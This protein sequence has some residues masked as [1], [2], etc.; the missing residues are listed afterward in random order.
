MTN[1]TIKVRIKNVYGNEL[2]YPVCADAALLCSLTGQKTLSP[3][4]LRQI[5]ALGYEIAV[6]TPA[7]AGAQ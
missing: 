3:M 6:E 4:H 7:L 5:K 1:R 2:V